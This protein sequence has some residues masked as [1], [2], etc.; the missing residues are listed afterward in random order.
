MKS[1]VHALNYMQK[2]GEGIPKKG[3]ARAKILIWEK[4]WCVLGAS[5]E[6]HVIRVK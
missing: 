1:F 6:G 5:G 3:R 4:S 2:E